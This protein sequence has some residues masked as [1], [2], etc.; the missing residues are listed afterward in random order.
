MFRL[1]IYARN[2]SGRT[3]AVG[4]TIRNNNLLEVIMSTEKDKINY[5]SHEDVYPDTDTLFQ[6]KTKS[7]SEIKNT[8]LIVLDSNVLL[9][10]YTVGSKSLDEIRNTFNRLITQSRLFVPAQVVRE[11]V[12][13]RPNKLS[14]LF[15]QISNIK[16]KAAK[17]NTPR[18][19]LFESLPEYN[20]A[21]KNKKK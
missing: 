21:L 14:E 9:L 17:L 4:L 15:Q 5:F 16:S 20:L 10:P 13:N 7:S 1:E 18:Y 6:F 2:V 8:C 3:V 19:P 11:F 12:K